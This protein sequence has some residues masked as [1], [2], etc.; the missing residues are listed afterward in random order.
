MDDLVNGT[1][2][3]CRQPRQ[4]VLGDLLTGID[5]HLAAGDPSACLHQKIPMVRSDSRLVEPGDLFVAMGG[6]VTDGHRYI[7]R[8]V[9]RGCAAVLVE[10]DAPKELPSDWNG[11]LIEV[12]DSKKAYAAL[13]AN[14]Y[15]NPAGKLKLVGITGTNGKTTI[16][17]LLEELLLA[18][19]FRTGVIGTVNYRYGGREGGVVMP[20]PFTTPEAMLLQKLLAEMAEAGV[21]YV[22]ME[23]SSH[24]LSQSRIGDLRFDVAAFTN[25]SRDHLDYHRT[26]EDYFR[27]KTLLFTSH[28]KA[29]AGAVISTPL[30][31]EADRHW[32][33]ELADLCRHC[34]LAVTSTGKSA[35]AD[36]RL[37]DYSTRLT[38]TA[39]R[40]LVGQKEYEVTT[41]LVGHFNV[42]NLL[43]T[44]AI[45]SSLGLDMGEAVAGLAGASGA[46]GRLHR[47]TADDGTGQGRPVVFVD[48]AHTPDA[49]EQVLATLSALPRRDL[50]CVFGCGGDRDAG[51]R[52]VMGEIAGKFADVAVVT[53]DNPRREDPEAIRSQI[54]PAVAGA[55]LG[56]QQKSWL[57]ERT[58]GEKGFVE[59]GSR[60]CAIEAAI[61]SAGEG[62]IVLIAGKGH[63]N[64]QITREGKHFFDDCLEAK[65]AL[66]SWHL[67]SVVRATGGRCAFPSEVD[68]VFGEV[69]TDSRTMHAGDIFVALKGENFDGHD[70]LA[71]VEEKRA[72]CL[73]VQEGCGGASSGK[74]PLVEVRDTLEALGDLA[75]FRR[76]LI[77]GMQDLAVIGITG[78]CGKTTVKEMTGA[79]LR[80]RWPAG[81]DYPADCVL[82][83]RG[84]LNNL[85]GMPLSLLPLSPRHRAAVLEMGMNA[86]GEI[87]RMVQIADPDIC[88]ITN[89]HGVHL[90]GLGS[91]EG[92]A[93]AKEE[94]FAGASGDAVL[95]VNLD[96]PHI[97]E[98][99]VSYRQRKITF[100]VRQDVCGSRGDLTASEVRTTTD[101]M[102]SFSLQRGEETAAIT[103]HTAGTHNVANAAAA[104]AIATAAGASMAEIAAGLADFRPADRRM[105]V[106]RLGTGLAILNDTYNANPASM[107]AGLRALGELSMG[108]TAAVLG[109]MFELGAGADEL[110]RELG[111][112]AA[113]FRL[114]YLGVVGGYCDKVVE[115][116]LAAGMARD[117]V[118]S[119]ADKGSAAAWICELQAAG[120]LGRED[121]LLVKGS[122]GM[123]M[124]TLIEELKKKS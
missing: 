7:G 18:Q 21:E 108:K 69:S 55:G 34:G 87:A 50:F 17:Y 114:D 24:A 2:Q 79:I 102:I 65:T 88:C 41:P 43:T 26:M 31:E 123:K 62:D 11:C 14:Y 100:A 13:A 67:K 23:V 5:Y 61:K 75:A 36:V 119:F 33:G 53:D 4:A 120:K 96:D 107:A 37:L 74:T 49:L 1:T 52:P 101:G 25:L 3:N 110:H 47:V 48:Y 73:I 68:R 45:V 99:A 29:G 113:G 64:Y 27:A 8:A 30:K 59:I 57:A 72:G 105:V 70:F 106:E 66:L 94:L 6:V 85:I 10:K 93:A 104:A 92:V 81:V 103:L 82:Q 117:S 95:I 51:K 80:R 54:V 9:E 60:R 40:L 38:D 112:T 76:R 63:E 32:A 116:A 86:P 90:E 58:S 97:A 83:T 118:R 46:P 115:G 91:I 78:S 109:D 44:L 124:E 39:V 22:I 89:V 111:V 20:S 56:Q 77:A 35:D 71:G 84:N 19:G 28:M 122:R 98:R 121:W 15:G 42:D 16:T 12:S